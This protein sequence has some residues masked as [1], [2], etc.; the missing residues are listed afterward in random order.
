MMFKGWGH[1]SIKIGRI[2]AID[3]RTLKFRLGIFRDRTQENLDRAS[4]IVHWSLVIGHGS[5]VMGHWSFGIEQ[6]Q[7]LKT[8][9]SF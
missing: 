9:R 6:V 8:Q 5:L 3:G 4:V 1:Q 2:Q 7:L